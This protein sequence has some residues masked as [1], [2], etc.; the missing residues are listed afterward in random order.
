VT[1]T[2]RGVVQERN[3]PGL[4]PALRRQLRWLFRILSAVSPALAA[5]LAARLFITPR[6]RIVD[7]ADANFLASAHA[8]R[9]STPTGVVQAYDW[10][11]ADPAVIL[12]HGWISHAA[13]L[14]DLIS[15]FGARGRRVVAFDAPAH[16]RSAGRNADLFSFRDAIAAVSHYCGTPGAVLAH[17][18]GAI[19]TIHWLSE[20]RPPLRAAVLVGLP[21]DVGYLFESF[22]LALALN[23]EVIRR[24]RALFLAR[25][26][27]EP[28][29]FSAHALA[30][31][32]HLP[33]LLVHGD[34]DEFIPVA[35]AEEVAEALVDG[36]VRI[37]PGLRHSAPLRDA[38]TVAAMVQFIET[39]LTAL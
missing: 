11:G 28:E 32:I 6:R 16:G 7:T 15:A 22:T 23:D 1:Q 36:Q 13:R 8:V 34:A 18:F 27:Q 35:Q 24:T 25:Y 30:A 26:G 12:V 33:V 2:A 20:A 10:A 21:R 37:V 14:S 29:A 31:Q 17:S 4:T 5:R 19:A 39:R 38:A 9:L 3:I